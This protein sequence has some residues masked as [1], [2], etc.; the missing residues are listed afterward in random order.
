MSHTASATKPTPADTV[1]ASRQ[2][3]AIYATA[4][5]NRLRDA[6]STEP[7]EWAEQHSPTESVQVKVA[8]GRTSELTRRREMD[9]RL[10]NSMTPEQESAAQQI[11]DGF[12]LCTDGT[13]CNIADYGERTGRGKSH[14]NE[15]ERSI[16]LQRDYLAWGRACTEAGLSHSAAM[17]ILYFGLPVSEVDRLRKRKAPWARNN[18]FNALT[19]FARLRGWIAAEADHG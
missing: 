13:T 2:R 1:L 14:E 16:R 6:E 8:A 7:A 17:D 9:A 5:R 11:R 12:E 4:L 18:L 15:S 19:L 10:W 3:N